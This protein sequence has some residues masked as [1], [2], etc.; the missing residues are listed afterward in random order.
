MD[1]RDYACTFFKDWFVPHYKHFSDLG[2]VPRM[3]DVMDVYGPNVL[4][5][6]E[7]ILNEWGIDSRF[8]SLIP[9]SP[10]KA[11]ERE[12]IGLIAIY[13]RLGYKV[14]HIFKHG[15]D[16]IDLH[17]GNVVLKGAYPLIIDWDGVLWHQPLAKDPEEIFRFWAKETERLFRPCDMIHLGKKY[18]SD[19]VKRVREAFNESFREE[20]FS[21]PECNL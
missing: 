9:R 7:V 20:L 5:S 15:I 21:S 12:T 2:I 13:E 8:G 6:H 10:A 3:I 4:V 1:S 17:A 11:T 14:G 18:D 19:L 16:H